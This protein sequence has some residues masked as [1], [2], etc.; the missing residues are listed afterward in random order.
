MCFLVYKGL[1][2][3][4]FSN[5]TLVVI[6]VLLCI[7]KIVIYLFF[8]FFVKNKYPGASLGVYTKPIVL[9]RSKRRVKM[10]AANSTSNTSF[11]RCLPLPVSFFDPPISSR[12]FLI[13]F[14]YFFGKKI[15]RGCSNG[16]SKFSF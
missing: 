12:G 16:S 7:S 4:F 8:V 1:T 14:H 6:K 5:S 2:I 11:S 13:I 10:G 15:K 9:K 3:Y